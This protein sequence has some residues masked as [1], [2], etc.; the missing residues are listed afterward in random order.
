MNIKLPTPTQYD[1]K[2]HQF[3]EWTGEVKAYLTLHNIFIEDLMEESTKTQA[4]VIAT[5]QRDAVAKDL[6]RFTAR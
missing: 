4:M 3:N 2:S 1:G 6:R 5:M